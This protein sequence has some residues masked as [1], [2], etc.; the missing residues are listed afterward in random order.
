MKLFAFT[1]TTFS[2]AASTFTPAYADEAVVATAPPP[3]TLGV[4]ALAVL[5][6]GDY[7]EVATFGIGAAARLEIPAGAG[8]VTGRLGAIFHAIN[9]QGGLADAASLTLIPA[10]VGYRYP[11]GALYVAGE[12]GVTFAHLS[13]DTQFGSMSDTDSELGFAL[14]AGA[15][16]GALDLRAGLFAPDASDAVG[17]M[18]SAGYDFAAF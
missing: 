18:A 15:R 13:A 7:A 9:D 17:V 10:Y 4:D 3:K 12:L 16:H 14:M 11:L 6:V 5:P 8:F 1:A 2:L